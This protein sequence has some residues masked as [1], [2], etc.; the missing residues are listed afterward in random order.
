[1]E[2]NLA[3]L[4]TSGVKK[5]IYKA[6]SAE[7][8]NGRKSFYEFF[9]T[10]QRGRSAIEGKTSYQSRRKARAN[11]LFSISWTFKVKQT[12]VYAQLFI[13]FLPISNDFYDKI[14]ASHWIHIQPRSKGNRGK[15]RIDSN[16]LIIRISK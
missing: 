6:R 15:T 4:I 5:D 16:D 1:M 3:R 11:F 10:K 12:L 2:K 13:D 9:I 8:G 14:S 7:A